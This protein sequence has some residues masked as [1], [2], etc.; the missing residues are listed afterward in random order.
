MF[1]WKSNHNK[2]I[3]K[4]FN[5][6]NVTGS[7]VIE[8]N[9]GELKDAGLFR[10]KKLIEFTFGDLQLTR[11]LIYSKVDGSEY[12][13]E[14]FP[15]GGIQYETY[16]YSMTD[17]IPFSEDFIDV[18]GQLYLTTPQGDEYIRCTLPECED[19]IDGTYGAAKVYD[20]ESDQIEK[21]VDVT[22]WDYQRDED[23][24]TKYLNIEMWKE[25]G[26]FRIFTG[27]MLEEVFYKFY[28]TSEE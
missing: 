16:L 7:S 25:N 3:T 2:E 1:N 19:R 15:S 4:V 20:I 12:V 11:Y 28:Q 8:F 24:I 26:M 6:L 21:T 9:I 27:E 14:V 23:G 13:F 17:T 10:F 18:A 5:P 22:T